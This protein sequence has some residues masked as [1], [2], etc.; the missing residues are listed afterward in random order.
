[1]LQVPGMQFTYKIFLFFFILAFARNLTAQDYFRMSADFTTKVKPAEG[2]S[3]L[4]KGKVYYDKYTKELIYDIRFPAKEKWI[5]Q[6]SKIYKVKD[7]TVYYADEIPSVNEF[8]VFHLALNSALTYFGLDEA[9]FQMAHIEKKGDLV[10]SYWNIPPHI[11]KMI[12]S[13]AVAKKQNSLHSVIVAGEDNKILNKQFFKDYIN[14][15]GFEFPGTIVQIFYDDNNSRNYQ[16]MEFE[17]IV[18]ND[19]VNEENYHYD[20]EN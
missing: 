10:I 7:D 11:Q 16:V 12:T 9:Q 19:A 2:K 13:I 20:L 4:T 8:T 5:V 17:N 6:D 18:V 3:T 1:M 14:I 15:E